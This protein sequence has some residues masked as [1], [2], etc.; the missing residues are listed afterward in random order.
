VKRGRTAIVIAAAV[1]VLGVVADLLGLLNDSVQLIPVVG[2]ALA[3]A[4]PFASLIAT[5]LLIAAVV[6][7]AVILMRERRQGTAALQRSRTLWDRLVRVAAANRSPTAIAQV[8]DERLGPLLDSLAAALPRT[9]GEHY[10]FSVV[11]VDKHGRFHFLAS[12][13]MDPAA[14]TKIER[15][16]S[17]GARRS[18]YAS[19]LLD[20]TEHAHKIY[21]STD[22]AYVDTRSARTSA[23]RASSSSHH[24][25]IPIRDVD[26]YAHLPQNTLG[27][28][29]IGIPKGF[30][31]DDEVEEQL[32]AAV[33]PV[34]RAIE[35][36]L[37]VDTLAR[38]STRRATAGVPNGG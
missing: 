26:L 8:E 9:F 1:V 33:M 35:V 22:S 20:P 25:L 15:D 10:K 3:A 13:G 27:I 12:R 32:V 31:V 5:G 30:R 19:L 36:I 6:A 34:V 38:S 21:A 11:T 14:V 29:S 24:L 17:L 28:V 16:A 4:Q 7:L 2:S 23:T 37:L 18:F